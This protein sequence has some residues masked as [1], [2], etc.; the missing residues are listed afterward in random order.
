MADFE[1]RDSGDIARVVKNIRDHADSKAIRK[2]MFQGL[3]RV[4]K[5][6]RGEMKEAIPAALPTRG[7]LS[8]SVQGSTRSNTSA[9]AGGVTI[10]FKNRKHDIRTLTGRRLRH[11]V[12]GNR[13]KWVNQTEGV[14]PSIFMGEFDKQKPEVQRAILRVMNDIARKVER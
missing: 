9:R 13:R 10:W 6:V 3:N 12:W 1:I 14:Q 11:P 5:D 7:G 2:E 8:A 4:S